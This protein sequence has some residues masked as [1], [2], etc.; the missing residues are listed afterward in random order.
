MSTKNNKKTLLRVIV[1]LF[2]LI[3]AAVPVV[4]Y[5]QTTGLDIFWWTVDAGGGTL[6]GDNIALDGTIGQADAGEVLRGGNYSLTGG[7]W[8]AGLVGYAEPPKIYLPVLARRMCNGGGFESEPNNYLD[9]ADLLCWGKP[10]AGA[11]DGNANTGDVFVITLVGGQATGIKLITS[12][13][14]GVQLVLY[15]SD[16]ELLDR[17]VTPED[18]EFYIGYTA[19]TPGQFYIYVFSDPG[20]NNSAAYTLTVAA[21]EVPPGGQSVPTSEDNT[22]PLPQAPVR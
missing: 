5:A 11:H 10:L 16:A 7:Y 3:L 13:I 17:D 19:E 6:T 20:A 15:A 12:D 1:P 22:V 14:T 4:V 21:E 18:N 9:E 8:D 2:V